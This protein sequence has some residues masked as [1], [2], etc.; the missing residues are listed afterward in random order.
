MCPTRMPR[1][2]RYK[3]YLNKCKL[4]STRFLKPDMVGSESIIG[5]NLKFFFWVRREVIIIGLKFDIDICVRWCTS[6]RHN[7][8]NFRCYKLKRNKEKHKVLGEKIIND[9]KL[10]LLATSLQMESNIFTMR[11]EDWNGN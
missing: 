8:L 3:I 9:N 4:N 1:Q 7:L 11:F 2:V 5:Y 6:D 10:T